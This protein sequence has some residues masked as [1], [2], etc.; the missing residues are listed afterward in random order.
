MK[1]I[2][3]FNILVV[4]LGLVMLPSCD[5]NK[6]PYNSIPSIVTSVSDA[7]G[8]R[9]A[10]YSRMKGL[11]AGQSMLYPDYQADMFAVP[12]DYGNFFAD[13]YRWQMNDGS[14]DVSSLWSALYAYISNANFL[15]QGI[16]DLKE[17]SNAILSADD[18][19]KLDLIYGEA[20]FYRAFYYYKLAQ[21]FCQDYDAATATQAH[22]G[23]MM[24][25]KPFHSP[26]D[27]LPRGTLQELMDLILDDLRI[28]ESNINVEGK[29]NSY[30]ITS[31]IVKA[32]QARIALSMKDYP[33]AASLATSIISSGRYELALDRE[34]FKGMWTMDDGVDGTTA[35]F[36]GKIYT[37]ASKE[38]LWV[39]QVTDLNDGD[40]QPGRY[41]AAFRDGENLVPQFLPNMTLLNSY[42][43]TNDIRFD[44]FFARKTLNIE[45]IGTEVLYFFWKYP[46]NPK[47]QNATYSLYKHKGKP[48]RLAELYLIA[49]E[50]YYYAN[51]TTEANS[52][53]NA[54]RSKRIEGWQNMTYGGVGLFNEIQLER[55][56]ELCG[57]G[58]RLWDLRRWKQGFTRGATQ[59]DYMFMFGDGYSNHSV[60]TGDYRFI[61][62]IPKT[63][64]DQNT[65][66]KD[67]Q[68]PG[69]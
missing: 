49:A 45:N 53:L 43:Q 56:R 11:T 15:I 47:L 58:F 35:A 51:N 48:F 41:F 65:Q 22:T 23:V 32:F 37:K 38:L 68:N 40:Q 66:L 25:T 55:T 50:A 18:I 63:E 30:Y 46:G 1:K 8:L 12:A 42:D 10:M 9:V 31:D 20:H 59:E 27:F 3:R 39:I 33:K 14:G 54:L 57:E 52:M 26:N 24:V 19:K 44:A 5:M 2:I 16:D 60:Q 67:Q 4:L 62:P 29:A 7:E 17:S 36:D 21:L 69:Y 64:T 13:F 6:L 61:W 28:A 34:T